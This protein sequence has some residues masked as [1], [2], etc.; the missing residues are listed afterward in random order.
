M[1]R[2]RRRGRTGGVLEH[3]PGFQQFSGVA[4]AAASPSVH[5]HPAPYTVALARTDLAQNTDAVGKAT[6]ATTEHHPLK[7]LTDL[8]VRSFALLGSSALQSV[9][10]SFSSDASQPPV[11]HSCCPKTLPT[12]TNS[13]SQNLVLGSTSQLVNTV[14]CQQIEMCDIPSLPK[15]GDRAFAQMSMSPNSYVS[16]LTPCMSSI[17]DASKS[18]NMAGS[19]DNMHDGGMCLMSDPLHDLNSMRRPS[20]WKRSLSEPNLGHF[21]SHIPLDR[22]ASIAECE[23]MLD[24]PDVAMQNTP[25]S[26]VIEEAVWPVMNS[27]FLAMQMQLD[28][29]TANGLNGQGCSSDF[30][31]ENMPPE[32]SPMDV[33]RRESLSPDNS[34]HKSCDVEFKQLAKTSPESTRSE[35]S[36]V[37]LTSPKSDTQVASTLT[38]AGNERKVEKSVSPKRNVKRKISAPKRKRRKPKRSRGRKSCNCRR[39]RCLKLYCECFSRGDTCLDCNC[40]GCH[41]ND[42]YVDERE[43][44][45]STALS[46]DSTAFRPKVK[47]TGSRS[48]HQ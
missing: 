26:S 47:L 40:Y 19:P 4:N 8:S 17:S 16:G 22:R 21:L 35:A 34:Q 48:K 13:T 44:A 37:D 5:A 31:K 30:N 46:R 45:I 28:D 20:R 10:L 43:I 32:A 42:A 3:F 14:D 33:S 24:Q 41:N 6:D 11:M 7:Q 25:L 29:V 9:T 18:T 27:D 12:S 15:S 1:W 2:F 23:S 38:D 39:S 36:H